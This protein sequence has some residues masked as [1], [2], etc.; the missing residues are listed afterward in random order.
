MYNKLFLW[1][2]IMIV[3]IVIGFLSGDTYEEL[4]HRIK[5]MAI[6]SFI[7]IELIY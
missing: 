4:R 6:F 1:I 5:F 7:I 2:G 3:S